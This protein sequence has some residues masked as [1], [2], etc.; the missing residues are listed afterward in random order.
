VDRALARPVK[1]GTARW[2]TV[3]LRVPAS[4]SH[5]A[6]PGQEAVARLRATTVAGT[7]L[8]ADARLRADGHVQ[9]VAAD[10]RGLAPST[11]LAKVQVWVRGA[12]LSQGT[13]ETTLRR[14]ALAR[15][16]S[17][18]TTPNLLVHGTITTA[19]D[20]A[21]TL[22]LRLSGLDSDGVRGPALLRSCG[23]YAVPGRRLD[24]SRL[25][26]GDVDVVRS[27][28][29][30]ATGGAHRVCLDVAGTRIEVPVEAPDVVLEDFEDGDA[31]DW[32]P[33]DGVSGVAVVSSIANGPGTPYSGTRA[34]EA[35]GS[36]VDPNVLRMATRRFS[37]PLDL[38]AMDELSV[39]LDSYGGATGAT[40]YT[41]T[42]VVAASDGSS[43]R[44]DLDSFTPD[45]W[46]RVAVP[47]AGWAG[48]GE[49]AS[50]T[51]GMRALGSTLPSWSPRFQIDDLAVHPGTARP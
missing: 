14:V 40:G 43:V 39:Q 48:R 32:S 51:V 37:Q 17:R 12:G 22:I 19:P 13:T 6:L 26:R 44:T 9:T 34:L 21:S 27:P 42:L 35:T 25:R 49:V 36:E 28:I 29:D 20:L 10:L 8:E 46:N 47:L 30:V 23:G 11:R 4:G 33:G 24:L 15:H 50:V 38:T 3:H 18:S 1:V 5:G 31:T 16:V 45:R 41:A 7:V 2:L